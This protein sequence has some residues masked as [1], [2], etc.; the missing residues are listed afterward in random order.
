M[1]I[2]GSRSG[3]GL[4]PV[5]TLCVN[6]TIDV[7]LEVDTFVPNHKI[8]AT[9]QRRDPGGGGV[10][11]ARSLKRLGGSC[12]AV[13]TTGGAL[14]AELEERL[15]T[16]RVTVGAVRISE[17][18]RESVTIHDHNSQVE[19]R[20]VL[21]GPR[22]N[23]NELALIKTT[24]VESKADFFVLSGRLNTGVP[25]DWYRQCQEA[26]QPRNV[27]VDC[28]MPAL[29]DSVRGPATLIKPSLR[30]LESLVGTPLRTSTEIVD[31]A[32]DVLATGDVASLLISLGSTGAVLV[33]RNGSPWWYA[34]PPIAAVESTVG[35][36]DAMVAGVVHFLRIGRELTDA[37]RFGVAAGSAAALTSGTTLF[38]PAQ[39]HRLLEATPFPAR[40]PTMRIGEERPSDA[41][42]GWLRFRQRATALHAQKRADPATGPSPL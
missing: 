32:Q 39:A 15:G 37:V 30:E 1:S 19:Y 27:V 23:G 3:P 40:E 18:T 33:S 31:A 26:L 4:A 12:D 6:P 9:D 7:S 16:E 29:A 42:R 24:L 13:I 8:L 34:T 38:R 17:D 20:V 21:P 10:N 41:A 36:G 28:A 35:C 25:P 5:T 11:V 14:G 2:S 22:L